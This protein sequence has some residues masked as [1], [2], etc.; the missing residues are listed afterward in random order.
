[1]VRLFVGVPVQADA[2]LR[3]AADAL[4]RQALPSWMRL[5]PIRTG[6]WH[7]TV[8]F[9]G[10]RTEDEVPVIGRALG[11]A[12]RG[13]RERGSDATFR[14]KG[15]G[16]FAGP[17][18][19]GVEF[20]QPGVELELPAMVDAAL[21][22]VGWQRDREWAPHMTLGRLK[23]DGGGRSGRGRVRAK[24]TASAMG[25]WLRGHEGLVG[26]WQSMPRLVL[27]E[28][29]RSTKGTRHIRMARWRLSGEADEEE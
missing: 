17:V 28:S 14:V 12:T 23:P 21:A 19:C 9:L 1:M 6:Q 15:V 22:M 25:P 5:V 3:A 4:G 7:V 18:W 24:D 13:W 2:A 8:A 27:F 20:S 29:H 11:M 16:H 10:E 26:T